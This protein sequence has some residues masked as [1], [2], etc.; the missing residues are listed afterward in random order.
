MFRFEA[1]CMGTV[2]IFQIQDQLP[3]AE[4][5]RQCEVALEILIEADEVFSLYKPNSE[6]SKLVRGELEW[7]RASAVQRSIREQAEI[8]KKRTAGF[9]DPR[10][11]SNYDPSGLVKGWAAQNAAQYLEANGIRDFTLNAGG[12]IYLSEGL[13]KSILTRVGLSNLQPISSQQAGVNMVLELSG[14]G[15]RA[16]ATSGISE[17]GEHIWRA[18]EEKHLQQ[19]SVIAKDLVTADIWAT[20]LISGGQKAWDLMRAEATEVIALGVFKDGS[21][22]S[23]PGF[24]SLLA[25]N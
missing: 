11:D 18:S 15:Y 17:R 5:Q 4:L 21:I 7:K 10:T 2:F 6:I 22:I 23:T 25:S 13:S 16:V 3:N 24:T 14:S 12:D 19:V 1:V 8:W 20:A 9:F